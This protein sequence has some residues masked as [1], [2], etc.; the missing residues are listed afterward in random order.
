[1][2][3]LLFS[4]FLLNRFRV[5]RRQKVLIEEQKYMVVQKQLEILDSIH[6]AE[7]LQRSLMASKKLLDER[8]GLQDYFVYWNPKEK[9][10][11]DFYWAA[12]LKNGDFALAAADSTGHGVPGAIMSMMNMNALRE[13]VKNGLSEPADILNETRKSIIEI[14]AHDGSEQGGK[15]GMDIVLMTIDKQRK[16]LKFAL[17]NNP[18][19][20]VR[21]N[22]LIEYKPDKMPVGRHD[23]QNVPFS[24]Q[25]LDLQKGDVLYA[26]TD[27]FADQFGGEKGKKFKSAGLRELLLSIHQLPMKEQDRRLISFF[28]NWRGGLEQVDDVCIVGVRI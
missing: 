15:D 23:K 26:F 11:G 22:E 24:K 19:W 8:L 4:L 5:I 9:V 14:L 3:T 17:A 12:D 1:V 28:D 18:L 21:N 25:E 13:A 7:R 2:I 6:Y 27:G 16:K 10:S 20:L